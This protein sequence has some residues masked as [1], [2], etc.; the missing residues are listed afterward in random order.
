MRRHLAGHAQPPLSAPPHQIERTSRRE[1]GDVVTPPHIL[2][3]QEVTGHHHVL[4][5][6]RNSVQPQSRR[7]RT[8]VHH[9]GA[10]QIGVLGV[11]DHRN[12]VMLSV[13]Q[14][15]AHEL[16]V[17]HRQTVVRDP[18]GSRPDHLSDPSQGL[19]LETST[20][21]SDRIDASEATATR[22]TDDV[23]G[24]RAVVVY[25]IGIR[26][27]GDR[28][29]STRRRTSGS[30]PDR[31]FVLL[32][33]LTQVDVDVDQPRGDHQAGGV[34]H[35]GSLRLQAGLHGGHCSVFDQDVEEPVDLPRRIHHSPP[36]DQPPHWPSPWTPDSRYRIAMRT[37]TPLATCSR[38]T[39]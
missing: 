35:L 16:R 5:R 9:P 28:G 22:F 20:D 11:L 26:H 13:H 39:E 29:E 17:H 1:V 30:R 23:L 24:H 6:P 3:Q 19:A 38:I 37:A 25:R 31:L 12:I 33:R 8:L 36:M 18:P 15:P 34:D 32:T 10:A 2:Q 27:A 4:R 21:R 7:D 14:R